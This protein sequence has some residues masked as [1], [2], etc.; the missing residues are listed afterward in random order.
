[1]PDRLSGLLQR[2]ELRARVFIAA[3][4]AAWRPSPAR[5][6]EAMLHLMRRG[7]VR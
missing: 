6:M 5:A 7:P 2:F 4:C 1:M 3:R